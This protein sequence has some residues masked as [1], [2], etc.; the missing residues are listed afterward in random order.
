MSELLHRLMKLGYASDCK[1]RGKTIDDAGEVSEWVLSITGKF[2]S[3][4]LT[5]TQPDGD[6]KSV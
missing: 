5:E 3:C 2:A 6:M 4:R 1:T